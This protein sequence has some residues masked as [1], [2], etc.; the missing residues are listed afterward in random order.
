MYITKRPTFVRHLKDVLDIIAHIQSTGITRPRLTDT[1]MFS[2]RRSSS[3]LAWRVK[4]FLEAWGIHSP[5]E[6]FEKL[7]ITETVEKT[8]P[9]INVDRRWSTA[10]LFEHHD[11]ILP[12]H[13]PYCGAT[14]VVDQANVKTWIRLFRKI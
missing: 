4:D 8:F 6:L 1:V 2:H 13:L 9:E 10:F 11:D 12:P 5:F 14:D 3:K 7:E